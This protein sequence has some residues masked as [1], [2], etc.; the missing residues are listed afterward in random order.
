[1][2]VLHTAKNDES[3]T[4]GL[5]TF[6]KVFMTSKSTQTRVQTGFELDTCLI[7][8]KCIQHLYRSDFI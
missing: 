1:M 4:D 6:L 5:E 3:N 7:H 2:R 8:I